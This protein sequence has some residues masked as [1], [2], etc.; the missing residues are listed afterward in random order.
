VLDYTLDQ[1]EGLVDPSRFCRINRKYLVSVEAIRDMV[2]HTNSRLKL[3][4]HGSEDPDVIV[5]RERVQEFREW[6]DR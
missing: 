1:L 5:A 2:S 3:L 6:L 4:L